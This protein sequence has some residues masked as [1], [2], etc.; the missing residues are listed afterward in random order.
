MKSRK[1]PGRAYFVYWLYDANFV[2]LYV[3]MTCQPKRR[4]TEHQWE[5]KEMVA[6]VA[7]KRMSGPYEFDTAFALERS[8]QDRLQPVYDVRQQRLT[9]SHKRYA[10]YYAL[11][12]AK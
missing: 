9:E 4:W 1:R 8:E 12:A 3:G 5:R 6:R 2:C 11:R 7:H 10:D